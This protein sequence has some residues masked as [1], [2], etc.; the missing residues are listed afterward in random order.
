MDPA[1][2]FSIIVG[3]A[4]L[5]LQC[6][7]VIRDLHDVTDTYK[8]ADLTIVSMS[9]GLETIS[10]AW[11]RIQEILETWSNDKTG[12]GQAID[13][14]TLDQ[15]GRSLRGGL[16]VIEALEADLAPYTTA[17]SLEDGSAAGKSGLMNRAHVVWSA[18]ALK[19]HQERIRDQISSMNLLINVLQLPSIAIQRQTLNENLQILRKSDESAYS[20]V[21]S[22]LSAPRCSFPG[23]D[24][25]S[26]YS[27]ESERSLVYR[28]LSVD[29]ELFT[30]RVYKRNY[31]SHLVQQMLPN[32]MPAHAN[33]S[34]GNEDYNTNDADD[35]VNAIVQMMEVPDTTIR[36]MEGLAARLSA[37]ESPPALP[38][39]RPAL[40]MCVVNN[41]TRHISKVA[42]TPD[43]VEPRSLT[44]RDIDGARVSKDNKIL[45]TSAKISSTSFGS[46]TDVHADRNAPRANFNAYL[47]LTGQKAYS[48]QL[49]SEAIAQMNTFRPLVILRSLGE[50]GWNDRRRTLI[51]TALPQASLYPPY[52]EYLSPAH[53]I[54]CPSSC[55]TPARMSDLSIVSHPSP[56]AV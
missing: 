20:I 32:V 55:L 38:A 46:S 37:S 48:T 15:L 19:D 12:L 56:A 10:W 53:S 21:P 50:D 27:V 52:L 6:S 13:T 4:G 45:H 51:R 8:N 3:S 17:F 40:H 49:S 22:G 25:D 16:L 9:T 39:S 43:T 41:L 36:R 35:N 26:L 47:N 1:S 18:R 2:I 54:S 33:P 23:R 44:P 30:A 31:R 42:S 29:D 34:Q 14:A 24:D 5:A 7:K 28:E 11:S